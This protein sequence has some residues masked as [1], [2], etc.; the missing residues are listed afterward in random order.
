VLAGGKD[1]PAAAALVAFLR[2]DR[3]R[4]LI[5]SYGYET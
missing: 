2:S 3:A 1:N 5:R 4:A